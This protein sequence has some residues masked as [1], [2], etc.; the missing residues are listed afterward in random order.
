MPTPATTRWRCFFHD[1]PPPLAAEAM[2]HVRDQSE[3]PLRTPW[4]LPAWPEVPTSVL[5]CRDDR[6][7]PADFSRRVAQERLGITPDE[8]D[9]GH[10]IALSRPGALADRLHAYAYATAG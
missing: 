3:T 4:P 1:V 9:G 2:R 7:F 10:C 5:I 8:I 6:C